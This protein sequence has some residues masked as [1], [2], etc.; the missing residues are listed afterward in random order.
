MTSF[1]NTFCRCCLN[2]LFSIA[3]GASA[4]DIIL[5]PGWQAGFADSKNASIRLESNP[6]N[7]LVVRMGNTQFWWINGPEMSVS[8]NDTFLFNAIFRYRSLGWLDNSKSCMGYKANGNW[9]YKCVVEFQGT[10]SFRTWIYKSDTIAISSDTIRC[11][12]PRFFGKG[13]GE[14][15]LAYVSFTKKNQTVPMPKISVSDPPLQHYT[16]MLPVSSNSFHGVFKPGDSIS[17]TIAPGCSEYKDTAFKYYYIFDVS[18]NKR[19]SGAMVLGK[20]IKIKP[21]TPS[22]YYELRVSCNVKLPALY[23]TLEAT[24]GAGIIG[25]YDSTKWH[26]GRNP[27]GLCAFESSVVQQKRFGFTWSRP[28][29]Y[30][31][32]TGEHNRLPADSELQAYTVKWKSTALAGLDTSYIKTVEVWNE[33]ENEIRP[34]ETDKAIQLQFIKMIKATHEGVTNSGIKIAVNLSWPGYY[35]SHLQELDTTIINYYDIAAYHPY[36]RRIK[37]NSSPEKGNLI[38]DLIELQNSAKN[39]ELW[40]P[41]SDGLRKE[42]ASQQRN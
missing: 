27:F 40:I 13:G 36:V 9:K 31:I 23:A 8:R 10:P 18:G 42:I 14:F 15:F 34:Y 37:G 41:N 21:D 3:F 28:L 29:Y 2:C 24:A 6:I 4:A 30:N 17:W 26:Y 19:D 25:L 32:L 12:M 35:Y 39:K 7:H 16:I 5:P 33:P 11:L 38:R 22:G 20:S 1:T